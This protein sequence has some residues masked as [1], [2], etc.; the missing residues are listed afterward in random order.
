MKNATVGLIGLKNATLGT[1]RAKNATVA[2]RE[3]KKRNPVAA[4]PWGFVKNATASPYWPP[5]TR[6][7]NKWFAN[8]V[9][10]LQVWWPRG[11]QG[12]PAPAN[13]K[14]NGRFIV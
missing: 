4:Q 10:G 3:L 9:F 11:P 14:K 6:K 13:Q 12:T 2:P 8:H 7:P 5:K 1:L